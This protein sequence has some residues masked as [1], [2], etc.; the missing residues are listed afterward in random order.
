MVAAWMFI[1][2]LVALLIGVPIYAAIGGA[3]LL[4]FGTW[5]YMDRMHRYYLWQ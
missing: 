4:N 5:L 3:A 1:V 2:F